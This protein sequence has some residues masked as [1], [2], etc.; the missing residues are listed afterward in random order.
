MKGVMSEQDIAAGGLI[1][2]NGLSFS[3]LR[4]EVDGSSLDSALGLI[5]ASRPEED[6]HGGFSSN[7]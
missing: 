1:D 6:K 3:E 5:F 4:D 2:I 7:I